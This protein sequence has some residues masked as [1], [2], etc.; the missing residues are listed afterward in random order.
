LRQAYAVAL[1]LIGSY[2]QSQGHAGRGTPGFRCRPQG[3]QFGGVD[4][5]ARREDLQLFGRTGL[6]AGDYDLDRLGNRS[7]HGSKHLWECGGGALE[8]RM[9]RA[10]QSCGRMLEF[11][12]IQNPGEPG[13]VHCSNGISRWFGSVV[14]VSHPEQNILRAFFGIEIRRF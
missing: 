7:I 14:I 3:E 10:D 11:F 13:Q 1:P 12:H 2:L 9:E 8:D 5:I 4:T 6:R